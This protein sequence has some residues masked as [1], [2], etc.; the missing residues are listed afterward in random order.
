MPI[1][2]VHNSSGDKVST[3]ELP[4]ALFGAEVKEH[5][6]YAVV[7]YQRA[8]ARSGN[9]KVKARAEVRGGGRKPWKQKGTGRARQGSIRSPQWRG[10]GVVFGP[11]VRDHSFKLNKQV[12]RAA[13][14]SALSRRIEDGA[15][16]ILDSLA[17]PEKKTRQVVD[18][19]AKFEFADMLLV[20]AESDEN[21]AR[22]VSN[23]KSVTV[24]PPE[25]LNVYDILLRS[26][27]VMTQDAVK[28]ITD[29]LGV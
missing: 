8:K 13:L 5:L 16:T 15:V 4:E 14:I 26:N 19:M 24:V 25:G 27:L 28:A 29:R 20:V 11:H 6:L 10:G 23:L 21:I 1:I 12:R 9:H 18:F 22:S 2:D 3:M 17:L 7:R